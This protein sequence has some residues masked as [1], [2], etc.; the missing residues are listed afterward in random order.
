MNTFYIKNS[1][2]VDNKICVEDEDFH[3]IKNVL[4]FKIGEEA[5]F[6]D[7]NENKYRAK[8]LEYTAETAIFEIIEQITVSAELPLNITLF[9]GLP[10][11]EKMELIIQKNTELGVNSIIPTIMARSVVKLTE[12]DAVKKQ[13]RWQKIAKEAARSKWKAENSRYFYA[14]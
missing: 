10:K 8:L 7:E 4:R 13:E 3:H 5:Y 12:K 2:C 1:K 6:C 9:Q 11:Q 14:K